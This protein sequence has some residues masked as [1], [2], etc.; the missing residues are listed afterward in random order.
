MS[1]PTKVNFGEEEV[2]RCPITKIKILKI[3]QFIHKRSILGEHL[4]IHTQNTK[5]K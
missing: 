2:V 1:T 5:H 4:P 3:Q